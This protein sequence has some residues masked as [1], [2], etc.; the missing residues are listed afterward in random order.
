M[1]RSINRIIL[2]SLLTALAA[3]TVA[4]ECTDAEHDTLKKMDAQWHKALDNRDKAAADKILASDFSIIFPVGAFDKN[5]TIGSW[6]GTPTGST[7]KVVIDKHVIRCTAASA[8]MTHRTE[9]TDPDGSVRY[10]RGVHFF[11]K[12]GGNW[13]IVS[14]ASHAASEGDSLRYMEYSALNAFLRRDTEWFKKNLHEDYLSVASDGR[15]MNKET[16]LK[17]IKEEE[18]TFES[19]DIQRIRVTITGDTA[20]TVINYMAKGKDDSGKMVETR[21]MVTRGFAKHHGA[22]MVVSS[23]SSLVPPPQGN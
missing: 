9:F 10:G 20:S 15:V 4:A 2:C 8:T 22:W 18:R 21:F 1:N 13:L 17:N 11:E 5:W 14:E 16:V 23:H 7:T 6:N 12:R 19:L 3:V